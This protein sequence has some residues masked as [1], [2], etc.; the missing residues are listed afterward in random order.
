MHP[1]VAR[2]RSHQHNNNRRRETTETANLRGAREMLQL[3][4][5]VQESLLSG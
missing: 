5:K 1:L 4:E 2:M 3:D